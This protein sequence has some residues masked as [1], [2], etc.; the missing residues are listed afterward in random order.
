MDKADWSKDQGEEEEQ[1][2][3][4]SSFAASAARFGRCRLSR[5]QPGRAGPKA[6]LL[7]PSLLPHAGKFVPLDR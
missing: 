7:V 3:T 5:E 4:D 2:E 6:P 1:A